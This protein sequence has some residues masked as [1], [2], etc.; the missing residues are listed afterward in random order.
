MTDTTANLGIDQLIQGQSN[1]EV[2]LNDG[3][4]NIVDALIGGR[5]ALDQTDTPPGSPTNGAVYIVGSSPTGAWAGKANHIA[6]Y[7]DGW[8]FVTTTQAVG[9]RLFVVSQALIRMWDGSD[10]IVVPT[11]DASGDYEA[12]GSVLLQKAITLS[13]EA[14]LTA[15]AGG[16][17]ANATD[18]DPLKIV[19]EVATVASSG[20]SVKL[21]A[22]VTSR[23]HVVANHGATDLEV[24][25]QSGHSIG[26]EATDASVVVTP[27]KMVLF[28]P[29]TS[30]RWGVTE[31]AAA[32]AG[33]IT[34]ASFTAAG[35]LLVGSGASSFSVLSLPASN[36]PNRALVTDP[37]GALAWEH[38]HRAWGMVSSSPKTITSSSRVWWAFT[39]SFISGPGVSYNVSTGLWEFDATTDPSLVGEWEF[40]LTAYCDGG[41]GTGIVQIAGVSRQASGTF[42]DRALATFNQ[43]TGGIVGSF[44]MRG[45]FFV[46]I[47]TTTEFGVENRG[48]SS[49][50]H[51]GSDIGLFNQL[52]LRKV[53]PRKT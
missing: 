39:P 2:T 15:Y 37:T 13:V 53:F 17:Q 3:V 21:P 42:F 45:R 41:E 18:L 28:T 20:D 34:S 1:A 5:V 33:P 46:G 11:Q 52:S 6:L 51:S 26:N 24:F 38:A 47:G 7:Y 16:G 32:G 35:D 19:H 49:G 23:L 30:T 43:G 10:W 22:V 44:S 8:R 48:S 9:M 4:L 29:A 31:S 12:T 27:G 25:P 50:P 40:A 36:K 14:G